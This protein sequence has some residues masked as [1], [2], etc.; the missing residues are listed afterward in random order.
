M[1]IKANGKVLREFNGIVGLPYGTEYEI[2]LKNL[3]EDRCGI[4]IDIDGNGFL[5]LTSEGLEIAN[6]IYERHQTITNFLTRLGVDKET[7]ESDACKIEHVISDAS[8]EAI[9][10]HTLEI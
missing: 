8:F 10:N 5:T 7:A 9:K 1:A 4:Y 3:S 6:K 2:F